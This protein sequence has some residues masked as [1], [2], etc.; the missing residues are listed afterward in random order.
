MNDKTSYP[1]FISDKPLGIDLFEG[2]SHDKI[3]ASISQYINNENSNIKIIGLEGAWGSG[4]SN[5]IEILK[6]KYL[7]DSHHIFIFDAWGHQE[8]LQ[9]RAILEEMTSS[10]IEKN[11]LPE[12]TLV[13]NDKK[14]EKLWKDLLNDLLARKRETH[15]KEIPHLSSGLILLISIIIL[16]P[17][18]KTIGDSINCNQLFRILIT[19]FPLIVGLL[20][21]I[22]MLLKKRISLTDLYAIYS[23]KKLESTVFES[24][25]EKEPSVNEFR[26]WMQHLSRDLTKKNNKLIV[27]FDNMDRLL[28]IKVKALWSSIHSFFS[29][30]N[31]QNIWVI[32]TFDR[33]QIKD[34]FQ[35]STNNSIEKAN[36]FINKSFSAIYR[37]SPPILTDWHKL[38]EIKFKEAFGETEVE[39][40]DI[41]KSIFDL[42]QKNI[43]PRS[44]ISFINDLVSEKKLVGCE[45]NLRYIAVFSVFKKE[46]LAEPVNQILKPTFLGSLENLFKDDGKLP[47]SIASLVYNLPFDSAKQIT[48]TQYLKNTLREK[49]IKIINDY[50]RQKHFLEMLEKVINQEEL[51]LE[52]AIETIGSIEEDLSKKLNP[53][54]MAV[55]WDTLLGKQLAR[56][57]NG[58]EFKEYLRLLLINISSEKRS[59][60]VKYLVIQLTDFQEFNGSNFFYSLNNIKKIIKENN[61]NIDIHSFLDQITR[62]PE[63]FL[64]FIRQA[65][66]DYHSYRIKCDPNEL[67]AYIITK[68]PNEIDKVNPLNYIKEEYNLNEIVTKITEVIANE[69]ITKENLMGIYAIYKNLAKETPL[70]MLSDAEIYTLISSVEPNSNEYFELI[71]MRL[72]LG[73]D[74]E[75]TYDTGILNSI[76]DSQDEI[77]VKEISGRIEW[78]KSL[79]DLIDNSIDWDCPLLIAVT[80]RII[81]DGAKESELDIIDK[82]NRTQEIIESLSI[83]YEDLINLFDGWSSDAQTDI[84]KEN[85]SANISDIHF[86]ENLIKIDNDFTTHIIKTYIAYLDTV[87]IE[88]W[89]NDLIDANSI[90]LQTLYNFVI[91]NKQ[92]DVPDNLITAYKDYLVR[93]AKSQVTIKP[94]I[95]RDTIVERI[96][97]N[98]LKPTIKNIRDAFINDVNI[99]PVTFNFFAEMLIVDGKLDDKP[100]DVTRRILTPVAADES[101]LQIIIKNSN[102]LSDIIQKAGDDSSDLKDIVRQKIQSQAP[103]ENLLTFA[104]KIGLEINKE[105]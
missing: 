4:K 89:G 94:S 11:I 23:S 105:E 70:E 44:I 98:K 30:C 81:L 82:V 42:T 74:F 24:I 25:S 33:D 31:Y 49:D 61:Y 69:E 86:I 90:N 46:I 1:R 95:I 71:S 80:R 85:I 101:C 84:T 65:K 19:S 97:R 62:P 77:I 67:V 28:P 103:I 88:T 2:G 7:K 39:E 21:L 36:H 38:F 47:D 9:R 91:S 8:D 53:Q 45:V 54:K 64:D 93:I 22:I 66:E 50:A 37:V 99:T 48:L 43:T 102:F 63:I 73:E 78:Y 13:D 6:N 57:I 16:T 72:A 96:N 27:V 58:Q 104:K 75:A 32:V 35:E 10:L 40:Y 52:N 12:K 100:D 20:C 59:R 79:D 56:N 68:L 17:V 14:E 92:K 3:A 87:S 15:A 41:V 60:F 76:L 29:E 83:S 18:F 26:K 34:A 5:V 55:I 51:Q